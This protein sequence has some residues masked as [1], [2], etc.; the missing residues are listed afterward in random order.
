M[1]DRIETEFAE[2]KD[3]VFE[4]LSNYKENLNCALEDNVTAAISTAVSIAISFVVELDGS[5]F[6]MQV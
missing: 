3:R 1:E 2:H 4:I 6:Q 5:L